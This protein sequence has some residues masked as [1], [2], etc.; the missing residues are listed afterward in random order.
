MDP[1]LRPEMVGRSLDDHFD[2][3]DLQE[4]LEFETAE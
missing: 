1:E 3:V 2:L 4:S